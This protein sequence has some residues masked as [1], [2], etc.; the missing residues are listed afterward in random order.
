MLIREKRLQLENE[1]N[2]RILKK[3]EEIFTS[4]ELFLL[5]KTTKKKWPTHYYENKSDRCGEIHR[6]ASAFYYRQQGIDQGV[7]RWVENKS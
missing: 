4:E 1:K 5:G 3:F 2:W 7:E 6:R